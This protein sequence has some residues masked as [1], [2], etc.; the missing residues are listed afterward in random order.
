MSYPKTV[1]V[2]VTC[3]GTIPIEETNNK[4]KLF[5]LPDNMKVIKMS[6]VT[7]G[8]CN[9]TNDEDVNKFIK[10]ILH[11]KN[12]KE[13]Q[14]GIK[15]PEKY[16]KTLSELYK[17]IEEDTVKDMF[18]ATPDSNTE[19]RNTYIHHRDKSYEIITYNRK[20]PYMINKEYT[21]NKKTEQNSSQWDY[22]IY[23]LNVEGKPDLITKL[24]GRSYSNEN[25]SIY[26]EEILTFLHNNGVKEVIFL[27]LS[28][29]NFEYENDTDKTISER[30]TRSIRSQ[31][32]KQKL[33]GGRSIRVYRKKGT[34]KKRGLIGGRK[35]RRQNLNKIQKKRKL[36]ITK[37]RKHWRNI[38]GAGKKEDMQKILELYKNEPTKK[39]LVFKLLRILPE[40]TIK[41][42][43][44][45]MDKN[46]NYWNERVQIDKD[47]ES[48]SYGKIINGDLNGKGI[49]L[50]SH[51]DIY[52]GEFKDD[53][54]NG[55]G[56]ITFKSGCIIEGELK[57]NILNGKGKIIYQDGDIY[58]GEFKNDSLNGIGKI[59]YKNGTV[60]EGEFKNNKLNGIGKIQFIDGSFY[61]GNYV[62]NKLNGQ[63]K[64]V[65]VNGGVFGGVFEGEFKDDIFI[66]GKKIYPNGT[67]EGEFEGDRF[68][69]GKITLKNGDILNG[70]N[71]II[72]A[73][74]DI[75]Q[76]NYKIDF[77][78]DEN[79]EI[80]IIYIRNGIGKMTYADGSVYE[81]SYKNN[82][83]DGFGK[84]TDPA[85]GTVYEG[86]WENGKRHGK[87][88][89]SNA[90]GEIYQ[91]DFES[92]K[93]HGEGTMKWDDKE[94][95][96]TFLNDKYVKNDQEENR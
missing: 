54:L 26:M 37:K 18:T 19:L 33:N 27:D 43:T 47:D 64:M 62:E 8:V 58:E 79:K 20:H 22:G 61:E 1:I 91:G 94:R 72:Y 49:I 42:I 78:E 74:G 71:E 81:G 13:L 87:G 4:A 14:K 53:I 56:K 16:T 31:L 96:G 89:Q 40:E 30:N 85:D 12:K 93:R 38:I 67:F 28:C 88:T 25:V 59:T 65:H 7:H 92:G 95:I 15:N 32:L 11:K 69:N 73:N 45:E 66:R 39:L 46:P 76:G 55:I 68:I 63:G 50:Y 3:H 44:I 9:L 90:K 86:Q 70:P 84:F 5:K 23:C 60:Y 17:S 10:T 48:I 6:A 82:K 35:T 29:S 83:R 34:A 75:Y 21:R 24:K 80:Q 52:E 41:D 77:K 2:V 57:D 36:N 51:G